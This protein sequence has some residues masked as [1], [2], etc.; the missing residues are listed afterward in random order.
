[1]PA[2]IRKS[3]RADFIFVWPDL[4]SSPPTN[5]L[6]R[7]ASSMAPGTKVFC[8]EPL[9]NGVSS[10]MHATEKTVDGETSSCPVLMDCSKLSAVSFTPG[11]MSANRSVLAVQRTIT[12]S[13][14]FADLNS[15]LLRQYRT[16]WFAGPT[17]LMSFRSCSTCSQQALLPC[18]TLSA[19]SSWFA[20]IKS[21]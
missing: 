15:L 4:K 21:G 9:M 19:R 5:A 3:T 17:H 20:A 6:C 11:M 16:R 1:M 12:L 13:R 8:G 14:E 2:L 18:N 10:R 7:S